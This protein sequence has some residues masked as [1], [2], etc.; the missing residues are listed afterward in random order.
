M[1]DTSHSVGRFSL[2]WDMKDLSFLMRGLE[3][4]LCFW[5]HSEDLCLEHRTRVA[6]SWT[7]AF[8][9]I[10]LH[11][12]DP[13][14]YTFTTSPPSLPCLCSCLHIF[15]RVCRVFYWQETLPRMGSH[16]KHLTS[17]ISK[18]MCLPSL[19]LPMLSVM[20]TNSLPVLLLPPAF[21]SKPARISP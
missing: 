3:P 12:V 15:H 10:K 17:M 9:L 6:P 18:I 7:L 13:Y 5:K 4:C 19:Q 14:A 20:H 11:M 16:C 21:L 1:A 2:I 8:A